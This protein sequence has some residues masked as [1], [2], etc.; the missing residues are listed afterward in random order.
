MTDLSILKELAHFIRANGYLAEDEAIP[1]V[2]K[3][4]T[5]IREHDIGAYV[6]NNAVVAL[7]ARYCGLTSLPASLGQLTNLQHLDVTGNQLTA[8]PESLANLT[9]L[10]KLY[11]DDNQLTALS[12]WLGNLHQL[13]EI[14]ADE[15]RLAALPESISRLTPPDPDDEYRDSGAKYAIES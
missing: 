15:N 10:K 6:E 1:V 8:L 3:S 5:T 12:T 7:S 11:I 4:Q 9:Q 13:E 14:H 2:L